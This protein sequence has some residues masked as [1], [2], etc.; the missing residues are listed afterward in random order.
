MG[1]WVEVY[2]GGE[3]LEAVIRADGYSTTIHDVSLQ[4]LLAIVDKAEEVL[5][6]G[7]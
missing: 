3:Q 7:S 1:F 2:T 6:D 4:D 5:A